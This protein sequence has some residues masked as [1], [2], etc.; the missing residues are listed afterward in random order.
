VSDLLKQLQKALE[1]LPPFEPHNVAWRWDIARAFQ[2]P[3]KILE[4]TEPS[5]KSA[6]RIAKDNWRYTLGLPTEAELAQRELWEIIRQ[7][8]LLEIYCWTLTDYDMPWLP[9][10][11]P[12]KR[13]SE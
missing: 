10:F 6:Y 2:V 1:N 13:G 3:A 4:Q 7:M 11:E 9:Y 12:L 5:M 8:M